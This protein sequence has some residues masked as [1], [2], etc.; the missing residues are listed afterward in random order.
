MKVMKIK[1]HTRH[2]D[3]VNINWAGYGSSTITDTFTS[4]SALFLVC[5]ADFPDLARLELMTFGWDLC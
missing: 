2:F 4:R 1:E 3:I 5:A